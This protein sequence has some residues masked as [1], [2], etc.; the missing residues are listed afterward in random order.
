MT[1]TPVSVSTALD[2]LLL[3]A[4]LYLAFTIIV[5]VGAHPS[6]QEIDLLRWTIAT[7]S[8]LTSGLLIGLLVSLRRRS[9]L[10]YYLTLGLLF[11]ISLLILADQFGLPDLIVLIITVVPL[12]L[13][14]KDRAWYLRRSPGALE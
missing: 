1:K 11:G 6:F 5:A 10:A 12:V 3:N 7:L 2:L 4:L 9:A 14:I 13:L 8:I